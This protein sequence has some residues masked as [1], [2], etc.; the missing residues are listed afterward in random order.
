MKIVKKCKIIFLLLTTM[1]L[2]IKTYCAP[3]KS[4][5]VFKKVDMYK[6]F[7]LSGAGY[8]FSPNGEKVD[9]YEFD[10]YSIGIKLLKKKFIWMLTKIP[11]GK[12][13]NIIGYFLY[14]RSFYVELIKSLKFCKSIFTVYHKGR[15][16][17]SRSPFFDIDC[18]YIFKREA[19]NHYFLPL[20][21]NQKGMIKEG[22]GCIICLT[23]LLPTNKEAQNLEEGEKQE[24]N[25]IVYHKASGG[26]GEL[27]HFFHKECIEKWLN[28]RM[29]CPICRE[30]IREI[31]K[32]GVKEKFVAWIDI[33]RLSLQIVKY[34]YEYA[35]T[36]N[37]DFHC[38]FRI[39][40]SPLIFSSGIP[41]IFCRHFSLKKREENK[42]PNYD[43]GQIFSFPDFL[44]LSLCT[45][46]SIGCIFFIQKIGALFELT[47]I[48]DYYKKT[49]DLLKKKEA[50]VNVERNAA[51][52]VNVG[53][54][55]AVNVEGN[56]PVNNVEEKNAE[57]NKK[58]YNFEFKI[59]I[60][61]NKDIQ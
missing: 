60:L 38:S 21:D 48:K 5:N 56:A 30:D 35:F 58:G 6:T 26:N 20:E 1:G 34:T 15:H 7:P 13:V 44:N 45:K 29:A 4:S 52:P 18:G 12:I 49:Y 40:I 41:T 2:Q 24:E 9:I 53:E 28:N 61:I 51:P 46:I 22:Q 16:S 43:F 55:A 33:F 54:N 39:S 25:I 3:T 14:F 37:R 42:E 27:N 8:L 10:G 59:T 31:V 36:K 47:Y 50:Q 23:E 19:L 57:V 17:V 32:G 11:R